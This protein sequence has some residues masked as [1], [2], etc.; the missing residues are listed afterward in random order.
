MFDYKKIS[1]WVVYIFVCCLLAILSFF[2]LKD[3]LLDM[4]DQE[5]FQDNIEIGKDFSYFF[6]SQKQQ[7]AGRPLAEL[8][9]FL[10]Y[11]LWGNTPSYF[12]LQV[13]GLHTLAAILLA[14]FSLAIGLPLRLSFMGGILFLVNVAHFRA[15]H[16]IAAIEYPIALTMGLF[17]LLCYNYYQETQ[18]SGWLAGFY[19]CTVLSAMA[20]SA[21]VFLLPFCFYWSWVR[22]FDVKAT[23]R[24]LL[25]LLVITT[26][27]LVL[28]IAITPKENSTWKAIDL[29]SENEFGSS[30]V[31]MSR[32]FL[33]LLSRL[34]TTCHWLLVP[35]YK[36][37]PWELYVGAGLLAGLCFLVY[38]GHLPTSLFS[39][40]ILLSLLPFLPLNDTLL[41]GRPAGPSR[42]LYLA[43]AGFSLLLVWCIAEICQRLRFW[44]RY[45]NFGI[46]L[47]LLFSSIFFLKKAEAVSLYSSGRNYIARGK[48]QTGADQLKRAIL[49]GPDA[50]EL[51]DTY[52]RLSLVTMAIDPLAAQ[53]IV[54][55]ALTQFPRS[56]DLKI[57]HLVIQSFAPDSA[58][59]RAAQKKLDAFKPL[60]LGPS[61]NEHWLG[62]PNENG[63]KHLA[64]L[65]TTRSYYNLSHGYLKRNDFD[66]AI[67]GYFRCLEFDPGRINAVQDLLKALHATGR[68]GEA[69][70]AALRAVERNPNA[71]NGLLINASLALAASG[72]FEKA[73]ALCSKVLGNEP[74]EVQTK[75]VFLLYRR[76]LN[77]DSK[78]LDSYT[79]AKTGLSLF[80]G[81]RIGDC[82]TAFQKA[83]ERDQSNRRAH[84]GLGLAFLT[85]GQSQ[86]ADSLFAHGVARFGRAAAEEA[87]AAEENQGSHRP[88]DSG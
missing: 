80:S 47:G 86:K 79:W 39:V 81:G 42:Y 14:R 87:G 34:L 62:K 48:I 71:P 51:H 72:D 88:R 64:K 78:V 32:L 61:G 3:H 69:A 5:A 82:I 1:P 11:A 23:I 18:K 70:H 28:I 66:Q 20:I 49:R 27:G 12:H 15:V 24:H 8:F 55:E 37:Q 38:K 2:S 7:P 76:I 40:W 29:F 30:L 77:A 26:V 84:F 10:G 65:A 36:L 44:G 53:S 16:W 43:T 33:W 19:V 6:S 52:R 22:K 17:A 50:I 73:I 60:N 35:L 31:G 25:P 85:Q 63:D 54:N 56:P 21:M 59:S 41:L 4:D 67:F 13:V 57:Y 45:L 74:T 9:K 46:F 83:L 68:T 58:I 75:A